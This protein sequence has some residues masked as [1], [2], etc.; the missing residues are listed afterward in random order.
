MVDDADADADC[1]GLSLSL[2]LIWILILAGRLERSSNDFGGKGEVKVRRASAQTAQS[3]TDADEPPIVPHPYP[4]A[5]CCRTA[6]ALAL[7]T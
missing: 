2:S 4:T 5:V 1:D 6:K 3:P 7:R